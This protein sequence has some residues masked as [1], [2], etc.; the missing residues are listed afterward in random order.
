MFDGTDELY[1]MI[2]N[3]AAFTTCIRLSKCVCY[4]DCVLRTNGHHNGKILDIHDLS[5]ILQIPYNTIRKHIRLLMNLG[6]LA[7]STTGNKA[8]IIKGNKSTTTTIVVNP[9]VFMRG[10]NVNK[11]VKALFERAGWTGYKYKDITEK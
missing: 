6:I 1:K 9:D 7:Y 11:T 10:C 4:D 8:N 3:D 2:N 5:E